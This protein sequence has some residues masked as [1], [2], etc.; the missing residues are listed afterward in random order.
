MDSKKQNKTKQKQTLGHREQVVARRES[1]GENRQQGLRDTNLQLNN[2]S[3]SKSRGRSTQH[4][5]Y[6]Q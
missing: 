2:K 3:V 4:K 6:G 1:W 5:E